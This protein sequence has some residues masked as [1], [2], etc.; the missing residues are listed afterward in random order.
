MGSAYHVTVGSFA[1]PFDLFLQLIARRKLD[2]CDVPIAQITD[3]YLAALG[4]VEQLDLEVATE[5]LVVAATLVELKAARLLPAEE[6]PEVDEL[7]LEIRD[8]LY[9]RL[10]DYRLFRRAAADLER[11]LEACAGYLPREVGPDEFRG[12]RPPVPA[13][14]GVGVTGFT[15][16]AATALRARPAPV[17]DVSHL[18][19]ARLSVTDAAEQLLDELARAGGRATFSDLTAG[20][21]DRFEVLACF[22]ALLELYK[23]ERVVLDQRESFAPLFVAAV[24]SPAPVAAGSR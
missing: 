6:R 9:A 12:L 1:G 11:R 2:V 24:P 20:C 4:D 22:L 21:R 10:L 7:A 8:L 23:H 16:L 5:F 13:D 17:V 19:P 3:D 18:S 14:L 15:E